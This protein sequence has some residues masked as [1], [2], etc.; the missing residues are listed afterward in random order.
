M[1]AIG[2]RTFLACMAFGASGLACAQTMPP[3]AADDTAALVRQ[4]FIYSYPLYQ[5]GQLR[6]LE[7][8]DDGRPGP[9]RLGT[10]HHM[11]ELSTPAD[12]WVTTPNND[13]LY[14]RAWLDLARGPVQLS[15][16]DMHGRYYS[17]A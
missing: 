15:I 13:T 7:L 14:S 1:S 4:A 16:P 17:V 11:R 9:D 12:R 10:F 8:G 3:P 2:W 5:M 6:R